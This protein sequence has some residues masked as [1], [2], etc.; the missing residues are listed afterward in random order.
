MILSRVDLPVPLG[1]TTPILAPC[2]NE[3]VTLSRTTLSPW[4]LRTLRSVKTYSAM[5]RKPTGRADAQIGAA[6]ARPA[7]TAALRP[8]GPA[9]RRCSPSWSAAAARCRARAAARLTAWSVRPRSRRGP[10]AAALTKR[11]GAPVEVV[12]DEGRVD[13]THVTRAGRPRAPDVGARAGRAPPPGRPGGPS[14][15]SCRPSARQQLTEYHEVSPSTQLSPLALVAAGCDATRKLATGCP[16][17]LAA[18]SRRRPPS[19]AASRRSRSS[20]LLGVSVGRDEDRAS[21]RRDGRARP[22]RPAAGGQPGRPRGRP[23]DD[24]GRVSVSARGRARRASRGTPRARPRT[25]STTSSSATSRPPRAAAGRPRAPGDRAVADDQQPAQQRRAA[26]PSDHPAEQQQRRHREA[27]RR[28]A[29][30]ARAAAGSPCTASAAEPHGRRRARRAAAATAA[31]RTSRRPDRDPRRPRGRWRRRRRSRRSLR[32]GSRDTE[33][34]RTAS[35]QG[36][37]SA[38]GHLVG[39]RRA[40]RCPRGPAA[41]GSASRHRG[42]R[43]AGAAA[44]PPCRGR[45][46]AA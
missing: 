39:Q 33:A 18:A 40:P 7:S 1:P 12:A 37:A 41:P 27:R 9:R 22:G 13:L 5:V 8:P 42:A 30:R 36:R 23:V 2:R 4:A 26:I 3:R 43:A 15:R 16:A 29:S 17:G 44:C 25:G 19:P 31:R 28:R 6:P 24:G 32:S 11:A 20:F 21:R 46:G 14:P 38:A 10:A 45:G 35:A 34:R